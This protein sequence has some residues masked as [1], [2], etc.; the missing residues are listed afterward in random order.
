[1]IDSSFNTLMEQNKKKSKPGQRRTQ[2]EMPYM[3]TI[4]GPKSPS[5]EI[6]QTLS[7]NK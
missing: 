2:H 6:P 4:R 3:Y 7:H 1:M 5:F